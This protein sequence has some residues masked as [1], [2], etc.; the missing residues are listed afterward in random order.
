[1][2][3]DLDKHRETITTIKVTYHFQKLLVSLFDMR[4]IL[5]TSF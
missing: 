2:S 4:P 1:M 5:L 3:W